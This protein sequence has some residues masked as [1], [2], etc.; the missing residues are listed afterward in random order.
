VTSEQGPICTFFSKLGR[1]FRN[2]ADL[3]VPLGAAAQAA[4]QKYQ[5]RLFGR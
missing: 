1:F 2:W 5:E 4:A 3:H